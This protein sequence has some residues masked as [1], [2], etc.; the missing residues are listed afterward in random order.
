[1]NKEER[2]QF[3]EKIKNKVHNLDM[4]KERFE[5]IKKLFIILNLFVETGR[6]FQ[7]KIEF[8]QLNKNLIYNLK[9]QKNKSIIVFKEIK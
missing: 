4:D 6:E 1:M 2:L 5:G 7:G 3:V 9:N 8:F